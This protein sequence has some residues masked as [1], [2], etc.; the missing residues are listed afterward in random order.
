MDCALDTLFKPHPFIGNKNQ[1]TV[2]QVISFQSKTR[3]TSDK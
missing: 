2:S 3:K 1:K